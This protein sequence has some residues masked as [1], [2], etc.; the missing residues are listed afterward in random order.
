MN[1]VK[2]LTENFSTLS[3]ALV[4]LAPLF[5]GCLLGSL[6]LASLYRFVLCERWLRTLMVFVAFS[7][8]GMT[9][10]MFVGA[11]SQPMVASIL[12]PVIALISG[13]I[14]FVGGKNVPVKT[15]LLMPGGLVLMLVMLQLATWYMKLYTMSPG[16]S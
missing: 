8:F 13:Y 11:S 15:R 5:A 14:A 10:G 4:I 16:E 12:P 7:F 6:F 2:D 1:H 3:K 9:V